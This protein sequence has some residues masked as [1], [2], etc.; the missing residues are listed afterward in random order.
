MNTATGA[1]GVVHVDCR[2]KLA[3]PHVQRI[4]GITGEFDQVLIALQAFQLY[5]SSVVKGFERAVSN[6]KNNV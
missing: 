4:I 3:P 1:G 6:V 2:V 5:A